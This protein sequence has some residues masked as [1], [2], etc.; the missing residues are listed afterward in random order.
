M[1][2][3]LVS[4]VAVVV[5]IV[6][7]VYSTYRNLPRTLLRTAQDGA[8]RSVAARAFILWEQVVTMRD[9]SFISS[10]ENNARRL[11][12]ALDRAFELGLIKEVVGD[13]EHSLLYYSL[14]QQELMDVGQRKERT[15]DGLLLALIRILDVCKEYRT[16]VLPASLFQQVDA[17]TFGKVNLGTE[18]PSETSFR[19]YAWTFLSH[20]QSGENP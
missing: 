19:E 7:L 6:S 8:M 14:T 2:S 1:L 15:G 20:G 10:V 18:T 12:G 13:R 5:S 17:R 16:P 3:I 9:I 4:A 11:E